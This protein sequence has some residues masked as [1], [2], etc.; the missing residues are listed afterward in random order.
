MRFP[1]HQGKH[2]L[3]RENTLLPPESNENLHHFPD[4]L[5]VPNKSGSKMTR[6]FSMNKESSI[7]D[8]V[9][10]RA[11]SKNLQSYI[12]TKLKDEGYL[13]KE[14]SDASK[15]GLIYI[16]YQFTPINAHKNMSLNILISSF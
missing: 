14:L 6:S 13:N 9:S 10:N 4:A 15:Y 3:K 16:C 2:N 8:D 7:R 5:K 11:F 1:Q 12:E